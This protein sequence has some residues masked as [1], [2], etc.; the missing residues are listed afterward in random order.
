[1]E[2]FTL[3][4]NTIQAKILFIKQKIGIYNRVKSQ[5]HPNDPY[6]DVKIYRMDKAIQ[7]YREELKN[8]KA[9]DLRRW[10]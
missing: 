10:S 1:M 8:L 7:V 3:N 2:T 6:R 4:L 9:D 5:I